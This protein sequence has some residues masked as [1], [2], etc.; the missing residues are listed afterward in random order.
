M[1]QHL[2]AQERM[3]EWIGELRLTG[4]SRFPLV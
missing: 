3:Y 1:S 4:Q 2:V